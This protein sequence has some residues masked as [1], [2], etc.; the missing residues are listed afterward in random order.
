MAKLDTNEVTTHDIDQAQELSRVTLQLERT[1]RVNSALWA[2]VNHAHVSKTEDGKLTVN[3]K[4]RQL[5]LL[6]VENQDLRDQI[7][8]L[9]RRLEEMSHTTS[10]LWKRVHHAERRAG[11][12]VRRVAGRILRK[13]GLL[14]RP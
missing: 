11:V 12:T 13:I 4:D 14:R 6:D 2:R 9:E 1:R 3:D 7:A 8:S 10:E 5:V